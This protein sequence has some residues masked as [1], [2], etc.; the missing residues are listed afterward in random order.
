M[1]KS[2]LCYFMAVVPVLN[3]EK[4]KNTLAEL[5]KDARG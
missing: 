2:A 4:A 3:T 1:S 5:V